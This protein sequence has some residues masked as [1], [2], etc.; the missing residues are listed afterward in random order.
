[1]KRKVIQS[2]G[3]SEGNAANRNRSNINSSLS[4]NTDFSRIC[5]EGSW[6][7]YCPDGFLAI[8]EYVR[9]NY[10]NV[11]VLITENGCADVIGAKARSL[12][13]VSKDVKI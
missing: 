6:I 9:D 2:T 10:G 3:D 4:P 11:P 1:M 13:V 5:G 8:L 12:L 7:R